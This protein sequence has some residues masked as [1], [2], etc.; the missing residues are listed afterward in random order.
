MTDTNTHGIPAP[1]GD[2]DI[3]DTEYE[4]G[5]D[6]IRASISPFGLDIHNPVF[7]ISGLAIVAFVFYTIAL[8][9]QAGGVFSAMFDFTTQTFY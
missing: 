2:A 7:L 8:P 4:I 3:I 6:N 1:E 5:Q 9:E